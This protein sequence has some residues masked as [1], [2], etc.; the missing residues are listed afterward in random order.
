VLFA[1]DPFEPENWMPVFLVKLQYGDRDLRV[2]RSK[3]MNPTP[4]P[5]DYA[6]YDHV[7]NYAGGRV[8]VFK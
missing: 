5:K 8:T 2:E 6:R 4:E 7:I 1:N 3:T